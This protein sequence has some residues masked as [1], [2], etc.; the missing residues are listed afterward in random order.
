MKVYPYLIIGGGMT[1]DAAAKAIREL[2]KN[3]EITIIGAE[4]HPPYK[5]PPLSKGLWKDAALDSI[6]LKTKDKN[7]NL[8]LGTRIS[9]LDTIHKQVIDEQGNRYGYNKLLIATGGTVRKLPFGGDAI[10]YYRYLDDY[11][12]LSKDAEDKQHFTVLGGGFIGSEIAAGLR[13]R[14]KDVSMVFPETGIGALVYPY[15]LSQ[16]INE[17]YREKGIQVLTGESAKELLQDQKRWRLITDH[18][19][20]LTDRVVGGIGIK[21]DVELAEKAGLKIDKGILVNETLQ[22][23]ANDVYAA[24]DV[25]SIY[26]TVL[27][28][29]LRYEHEDNAI[30]MGTAAGKNMVGLATRYDTNLPY[31]YS[32][33]FELGYEAVGT[34]DSRLEIFE[35][36]QEKYKKG[37]IYYL[38]A[39]KVQGVLLW[40]V[41]GQVKAARE[42]IRETQEKT[43]NPSDLSGRLPIEGS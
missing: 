5:R 21:P 8:I 40:N 28:K 15:G 26:N 39:G 19:N 13:M 35:D 31:F 37:V 34:L 6:W 27:N 2:D 1:G 30:K 42:I 25:A 43:V 23:S 18:Y 38:N 12:T 32:D 24:G 29:Q 11:F 36:W 33:L 9:T 22:T 10:L 17:Y 16:F 3:A 20:L 7:I 41:W 4:Q 14:G